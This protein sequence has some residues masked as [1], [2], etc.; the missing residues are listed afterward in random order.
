[1]DRRIFSLENEYG[2]TC[3]LRG[4]RRLHGG[5]GRPAIDPFTV[6]EPWR[7]VV[8]AALRS[9]RQAARAVAAA[10]AGPLRERL[11]DIERGLDEALDECWA[12]AL[13]GHELR[14]AITA[15]DLDGTR[16]RLESLAPRLPPAA[17][18]HAPSAEELLAEVL[19]LN[20]SEIAR[21]Y[22]GGVVAGP[23]PAPR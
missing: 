15:M 10:P 2:V 13:R 8:S 23:T 9:R 3:T 22:D 12:I 4:Q 5:K 21:L 11:H 14:R 16:A 1:M 18:A 20:E 7:H 19:G 6:G 17:E